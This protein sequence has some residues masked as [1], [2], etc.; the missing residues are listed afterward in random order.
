[1]ENMRKR[2]ARGDIKKERT[3]AIKVRPLLSTKNL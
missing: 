2:I 1:M 3:E